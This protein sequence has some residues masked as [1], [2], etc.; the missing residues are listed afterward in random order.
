MNKLTNYNEDTH[1]VGENIA[2]ST[3]VFRVEIVQ[4]SFMLESLLISW[5]F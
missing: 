4:L 1:V 3:Q 2:E 5:S